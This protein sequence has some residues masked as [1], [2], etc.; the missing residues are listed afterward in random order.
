MGQGISIQTRKRLWLRSGGRCAF[1]NCGRAL[2]EAIDDL[3]DT[4]VGIECHIVAQQ[5][6]PARVARAV[7]ALT[8][9]EL[10]EWQHLIENRHGFPN[11]VLMCPTHSTIIDDPRGTYSVPQV[12]EMKRAHEAA[13]DDRRSG[14]LSTADRAVLRYAEIVDEW[15]ARFDIENWSS[16]MGGVFS[17]GHPRM[18]VEDFDR[19]SKNRE[20]LFTRVWPHTLADLEEAFENFRWVAQDLQLVLKQYPH[21]HLLTMGHVAP[22]RFYNDSAWQRQVEDFQVL[23]DMYDWWSN[24]LEDLAL[25]L[26]R[27]AN[28]VCTAVRE[29]LDPRYRLDEGLIVM[30]SGPYEDLMFRKH[31][32]QYAASDG[33][34]PYR[35]LRLFLDDRAGR[36]ECRGGGPLPTQLRLPG[37]AYFG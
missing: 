12:V 8:P 27:A 6:D 3:N 32:P 35:G 36:D 34:R 13:E 33:W 23:G 19:L 10:V 9:E 15:E 16:W 18:D 1:A 17:D 4:V 2:V 29:T 7:S 24:L 26:A 22:C 25:E 20:W 37:D 28:L 5:D 30:E 31:R 14:P 21:E 11:L